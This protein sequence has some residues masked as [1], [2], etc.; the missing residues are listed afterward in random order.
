V[1]RDESDFPGLLKH[2]TD[3]PRRLSKAKLEKRFD[4]GRS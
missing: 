1:Q 2:D 3:I 4:F